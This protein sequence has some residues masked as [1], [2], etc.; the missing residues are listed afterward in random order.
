MYIDILI[1]ALDNLYENTLYPDYKRAAIKEA[2]DEVYAQKDLMDYDLLR[3]QVH[4][5]SMTTATEAVNM[6]L[7]DQFGREAKKAKK[8][9]RSYAFNDFLDL[10]RNSIMSD[11]TIEIL[12]DSFEYLE[13]LW[14]DN[15]VYGNNEPDGSFRYTSRKLSDDTVETIHNVL[16]ARQL[17]LQ[18][19][20][21]SCDNDEDID[22]FQGELTDILNAIEN[23]EHTYP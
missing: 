1:E 23:L 4:I 5:V 9:G 10:A 8:A 7:Y 19:C 20:I 6:A 11:V 14:S 3:G 18:D 21:L 15:E 22:K 2:L 13:D 16:T 12:R 17:D